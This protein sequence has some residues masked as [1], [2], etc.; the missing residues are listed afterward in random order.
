[1]T[2]ISCFYLR[3]D[4]VNY[5]LAKE[6][7]ADVV[8]G[9]SRHVSGNLDEWLEAEESDTVASAEEVPIPKSN[10]SRPMAGG[11]Q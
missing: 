5:Q 7:A 10:P 9:S 2:I 1:M 6:T 4:L 11:K 8:P 3:H